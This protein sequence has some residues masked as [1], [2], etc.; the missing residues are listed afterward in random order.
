[1]I[2]HCKS[3]ISVAFYSKGSSLLNFL[4]IGTDLL[5]AIRACGILPLVEIKG[6]VF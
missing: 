6:G 3:I 1:M 5:G 4:E 2:H